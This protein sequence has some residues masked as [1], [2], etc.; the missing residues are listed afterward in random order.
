MDSIVSVT[1]KKYVVLCG[2]FL[3]MFGNLSA[4]PGWTKL[5]EELVFNNPP[6]AQCHASTIV[7]T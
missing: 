5:K 6:F 7:E 3:L 2:V 1:C 4:Q